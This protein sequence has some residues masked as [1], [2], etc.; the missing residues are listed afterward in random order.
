MK[1]GN[2]KEN[3]NIITEFCLN[4]WHFSRIVKDIFNKATGL[5]IIEDKPDEEGPGIN[6]F[7]AQISGIVILNG[8]RTVTISVSMS[9]NSATALIVYM[10][11]LSRSEIK[12]DEQ[13]DGVTEIVN[14][15]AGQTKAKLASMGQ[16]YTYTQPFVIVGDD[17]RI[18]QKKNVSSLNMKFRSG[19][20]EILMTVTLQ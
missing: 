1:I 16:R 18:I 20:I 12:L 3:D 14:M 10:S 7:R 4:S 15:I 6:D 5:D 19:M 17:H 11:D 9:Y 2:H 8:E 13:A